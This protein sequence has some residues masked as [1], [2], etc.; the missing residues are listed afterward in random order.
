[1]KKLFFFNLLLVILMGCSKNDDEGS[2]DTSSQI[3]NSDNTANSDN[4]NDSSQ[5]SSDDSSNSSNDSSN[6]NSG[7]ESSDNS[8]DTKDDSNN[9]SNDN[10]N[11]NSGNESSD[12]SSDTEDDSSDDSNSDNSDEGSNN[13][14]SVDVS[15]YIV[16]AEGSGNIELV[17]NSENENGIAVTVRITPYEGFTI[18][19]IQGADLPENTYDLIHDVRGSFEIDLNFKGGEVTPASVY[20]TESTLW[21]TTE[22]HSNSL[23]WHEGRG[24]T[25]RANDMLDRAY[26]AS[27]EYMN[28]VLRTARI[29]WFPLRQTL[30][31]GE[32]H[33][34]VANTAGGTSCSTDEN[35]HIIDMRHNSTAGVILHEAGH[36]VDNNCSISETQ[37]QRSYDLHSMYLSRL[38]ESGGDSQ[39]HYQLGFGAGEWF[40]C[41][42]AAYFDTTGEYD[43]SDGAGTIG[44]GYDTGREGLQ[45]KYPEM[46]ELMREIYD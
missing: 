23:E 9:S 30:P 5:D 3:E 38:V 27:T 22:G 19:D 45:N 33:E 32:F 28:E 11:E 10:S 31:N 40:A 41:S 24:E 42:T 6:E 29:L 20:L 12:S 21:Y 35:P 39:L 25:Y 46:F 34:R 8:S 13:S 16:V 7:N 18:W 15:Q 44:Q 43:L 4:S 37:H 14:T 2:I 26:E 17:S 36:N 1:M